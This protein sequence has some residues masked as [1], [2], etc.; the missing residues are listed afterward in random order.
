M[1]RKLICLL[2]ILLLGAAPALAAEAVYGHLTTD[3]ERVFLETRE[4]G[5][6][7]QQSVIREITDG[8]DVVVARMRHVTDCF[9]AEDMLCVAVVTNK[10]K[11]VALA[12]A[13]YGYG[14]DDG[15]ERLALHLQNQNGVN[16][17]HYGLY[18]MDG[19]IVL[20]TSTDGRSY[21]F[22][23]AD[24]TVGEAFYEF[25]VRYYRRTETY[26]ASYDRE[27][28]AVFVFDPAAM[29]EHVL[30]LEC[31]P[32]S[33]DDPESLLPAG[34]LTQGRLVYPR[35]DGVWSYDFA[36]GQLVR[37]VE[38]REPGC[39]CVQDGVLCLASDDG[40]ILTCDLDTRHITVHDLPLSKSESFVIAGE[41]LYIWNGTEGAW[42]I[43][44]LPGMEEATP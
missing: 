38:V 10:T 29:Q 33:P 8:M 35:E 41:Q 5:L 1:K 11:G 39:F 18:R 3:G 7:G 28:N 4:A 19:R 6:F 16:A 42:R 37:L 13:L 43:E 9:V 26:V 36:A 31:C 40:R 44:P 20:Q 23:S 25:P 30:P 12:I 32:G 2:L 22:V 21:A 24:G 15:E 17:P 34:V 27:R 14:L